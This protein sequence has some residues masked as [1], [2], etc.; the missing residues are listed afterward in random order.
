MDKNNIKVEVQLI[1]F[2][3]WPMDGDERSSGQL[4]APAITQWKY[5][6]MPIQ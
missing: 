6:V 1:S 3:A 2:L 5:S 4:H